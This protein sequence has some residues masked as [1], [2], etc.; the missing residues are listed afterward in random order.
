M[1]GEFV[2][3]ENLNFILI[4]M[5]SLNSIVL[6][7]ILLHAARQPMSAHQRSGGPYIY[8]S[9]LVA[10]PKQRRASGVFLAAALFVP[11][12]EAN[13]RNSFLSELFEGV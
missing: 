11:P 13:G 10:V 12:R 2:K 8:A 3:F 7:A 1:C 4:F 6:L 9:P 5:A